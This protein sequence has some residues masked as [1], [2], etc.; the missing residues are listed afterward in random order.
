MVYYCTYCKYIYKQGMNALLFLNCFINN[1]CCT[2]KQ[3]IH[4]GQ[5]KVVNKAFSPNE[6]RIA[7]AENLLTAFEEQEKAGKVM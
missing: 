1:S 5:I 3:I 6:E 7:W 4:P 2:G